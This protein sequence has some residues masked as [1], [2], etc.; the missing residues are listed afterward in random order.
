MCRREAARSKLTPSRQRPTKT[1]RPFSVGEDFRL[2]CES[3]ISTVGEDFRS[4]KRCAA[5]HCAVAER[6]RCRYC[7]RQY[8]LRQP[9]RPRP[10]R[11]VAHYYLLL[12]R[13]K[14]IEIATASFIDSTR[15][16]AEAGIPSDQKGWKG[17]RSITPS[18]EDVLET[19]P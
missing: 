15:L 6:S 19:C 16:V 14:L 3:K 4:L 8:F 7:A 13:K 17:L 12:A 2:F 11:P 1:G 5:R 9:S 10:P 18:V